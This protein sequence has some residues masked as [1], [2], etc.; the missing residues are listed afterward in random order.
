MKKNIKNPKLYAHNIR[1]SIQKFL[2][3]YQHST[4]LTSEKE[5]MRK[6]M[7]D[8]AK[9]IIESTDEKI[10]DTFAGNR[11]NR[12]RLRLVRLFNKEKEIER[13]GKR[14]KDNFRNLLRM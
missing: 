6:Q 12:V 9:E 11:E 10:V 5:Q 4:V 3:F 8:K 7:V 14:I 1:G 2:G 13:E